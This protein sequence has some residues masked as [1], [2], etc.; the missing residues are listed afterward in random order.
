MKIICLRDKIIAATAVLFLIVVSG[1]AQLRVSENVPVGFYAK[2]LDQDGNP[3]TEARVTFDF[4]MSYMAENRT[5]TS[6]VVLQTCKRIL[7][8]TSR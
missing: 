5:K 1:I 8:G 7:M 4:I 2:V 6:E 3:V